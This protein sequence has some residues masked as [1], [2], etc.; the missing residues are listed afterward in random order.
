MY[1]CVICNYSTNV[2]S[3]LSKHNNSNKHIKN[4]NNIDQQYQNIKNPNNIKN[5]FKNCKKIF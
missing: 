2:K 5:K 3:N 1:K 4:E